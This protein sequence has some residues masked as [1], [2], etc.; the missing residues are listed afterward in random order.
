LVKHIKRNPPNEGRISCSGGDGL[1]LDMF[2]KFGDEFWGDV[3][4]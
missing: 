3:L 1:V 2:E 4:F